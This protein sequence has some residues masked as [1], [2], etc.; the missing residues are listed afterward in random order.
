MSDYILHGYVDNVKRAVQ[1]G[2]IEETK[3]LGIEMMNLENFKFKLNNKHGIVSIAELIKVRDFIS[4]LIKTNSH[5]VYDIIH[6][7]K[8]SPNYWGKI[9]L[10]T[11]DEDRERFYDVSLD[12]E[13]FMQ[14][15]STAREPVPGY[16]VPDN[17]S[18]AEIVLNAFEDAGNS[19]KGIEC[20][21]Y[22]DCAKWE[23]NS[24]AQAKKLVKF[25]EDNYVTPK[26][27]EWKEFVG[28][29]KCIWLE[30]K[31]DFVYKK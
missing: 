9:E 2:H 8:K 11:Y 22:R 13:K 30:D 21:H 14:E 24:K 31:V 27:K 7:D 15:K 28:I 10:Q 6:H 25:I 16:F 12:L 5:I 19:I 4:E 23:T 29:K 1:E 20:N 17:Y 3:T 26:V 18:L